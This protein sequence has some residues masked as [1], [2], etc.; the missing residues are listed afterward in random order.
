MQSHPRISQLLVET[1]AY[2]D[3]DKPVILTSGELGIYY[4]NTEKL[5]QDNGEFEKFGDDSGTMI[6]HAIKMMREHPTF[7]EV[8]DI[9]TEDA[10][11]LIP[12]LDYG[13]SGGQRR[14]W[15]FSGPIA[16]RLQVPHVSLYK[17]GRI[18]IVAPGGETYSIETLE[19]RRFRA[20][21]FVDLLTEASS[22]YRLEEGKPAGWVPMLR[23]NNFTIKNLV[24]V[25]T[26]LQGGEER[27][28]EQGI[29]VESKVAIDKDFL[30][31]HSRQPEIAVPY[32]ENP[33]EW[34]KNYL[35]QNGALELL[36]TFNPTAGKLDRARKFLTRY[37]VVLEKTDK[38]GELDSAVK[39]KYGQHLNELF[40]T[41]L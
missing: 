12:D 37:K 20:L 22:C 10:K 32:N 6:K 3:L 18:E 39:M 16:Y 15:L 29:N 9:L 35:M 7:W 14:D 21:Q 26:R 31:A 13:I 11:R 2:R 33:Q 1:V 8:I 27:L 30:Q 17:D 24:A 36:D 28:R 19:G 41:A 25:V 38:L 4:I 23:T 40:G 34:S 5:V